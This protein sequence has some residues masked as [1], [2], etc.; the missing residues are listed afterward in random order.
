MSY[1]AW[2][3]FCEGASDRSY[4]EIMLPRVMEDVLC[5]HGVRPVTIPETP[6]IKL[7]EHGRTIE[8]VGEE[9]CRKKDCFHIVFIHADYGGRGVEKSLEN[10]GV[11]YCREAAK[12]CE[13]NY[14]R[15]VVLTPRHELEA[16]V[17]ADLSSVADA[18]GCKHILTA[19]APPD[20]GAAENLSDP[21]AVLNKIVDSVRG[22]RR[23]GD[24]TG[25]L[26]AIAQRQSIDSLRKSESFNN[27]E[28]L[29]CNAF[30]N[31]GLL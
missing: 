18:L 12:R 6:A 9:I 23:R 11:A 27:F 17:L 15:C 31:L 24:Y 22:R 19:D 29:L 26:T 28:Q 1:I 2:A 21:K 8:A 10:R 3:L 16:W 13:W 7:G 14:V 25:L 30:R 20:A 5:R 4:L